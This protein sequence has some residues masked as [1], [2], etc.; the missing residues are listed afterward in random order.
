MEKF[1]IAHDICGRMRVRLPYP[2]SFREAD[3]IRWVLMRTEGVDDVKITIRT[4]DIVVFYHGDRERVIR[5]LEGIDLSNQALIEKAPDSGLE[6]SS[7]YWDK[8]VSAVA[9]RVLRWAFLPAGIREALALINS[10]PYIVKGVKA[11]FSG[12]GLTVEVLDA[13]AL[14]AAIVTADFKTASS[15]S[16]L[17]KIGEILEEWTYKKSV[18]DLANSMALNVG[19]VWAVQ[20]DGSSVETGIDEINVDDLIRVEVGSMIPLADQIGRA[21]CRERV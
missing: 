9:G 1:L 10:L 7:R 5:A 11:L 17:L 8:M 14:T 20:P 16:F 4:A 6:I 13:S 2:V 21:S 12:K 3:A 19:K 15:V 18:S